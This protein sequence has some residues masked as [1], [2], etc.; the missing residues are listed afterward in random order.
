MPRRPD[1]EAVIHVVE[2]DGETILVEPA[3]LLVD[4]AARD[5]TGGGNGRQFLDTQSAPITERFFRLPG[6]GVFG[7]RAPAD[8]EDDPG[9]LDVAV[10]IEQ[11]APTA[12]T[13]GGGPATSSRRAS[14][15]PAARI[16]V[17]QTQVFAAR[18]SRTVRLF[19]A[20]KLKAPGWRTTRMR[21]PISAN[22]SSIVSDRRR[23]RCRCCRCRRR[24][25]CSFR[26]A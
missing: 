23:P 25:P 21:L 4:R 3:E 22:L 19:I 16:V 24:R 12:P 5:Q 10:G 14:R 18:S 11:L 1:P 26:I 15:R 20:E 8:P 17:Q 9:M 13:S 6:I 7:R 2:G